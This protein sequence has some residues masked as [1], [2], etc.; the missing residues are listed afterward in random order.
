[1]TGRPVLLVDAVELLRT[2]GTRRRLHVEVDPASVDA[3]H[4][5]VDGCVIVDVELESSID[6]VAVHGNVVVPWR[7]VCRRCAVALAIDVDVDIDE[8]YAEPPTADPRLGDT[9]QAD[10]DALPI[11]R[12]QFDLAAMVRDETLLAAAVDR[13][14]RPDCAGLCPTCGA[15]LN[16]GACTCTVAPRDERWAV[17]EALR[18]EPP[19]NEPAAN[20]PDGNGSLRR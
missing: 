16:E 7:G 15:D 14:C 18:D 12:G 11:V 2:P 13:L 3:V 17:L 5:N 6:D 8:R 4:A 19:A 1:M 10:P 20:E 9:H